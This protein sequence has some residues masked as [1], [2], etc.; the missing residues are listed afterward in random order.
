MAKYQHQPKRRQI[1]NLRIEVIKK[2]GKIV[3]VVIWNGK[4]WV[5]DASIMKDKDEEFCRVYTGH[6]N[7]SLQFEYF[8]QK[9][10][11]GQNFLELRSK[12]K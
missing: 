10:A 6:R 8:E 3:G 4:T 1:D 9:G 12:E 2:R 7:Q 11:Y 5:L